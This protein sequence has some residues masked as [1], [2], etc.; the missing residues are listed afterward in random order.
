MRPAYPEDL[1]ITISGPAGSGKSHCA[2]KLAERFGIPC[3]S[4]GSVFRTMAAEKGVPVVEFSKIAESN[5]EIDRE[6]D[7]RTAE[8]AKKG[9]AILE[10]RLVMWFS[11]EQR[12]LSFYLTAPFEE[13]VRRIAEREG[14]PFKDAFSKTKAREASERQR[15]RKIYS[16][17]VSDLSR[18]DFVVN[19]AKWDK[20]AIVELL[21]SII[22]LH[23]KPKPS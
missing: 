19:T 3:H 7:R 5:H 4:A 22:E 8:L 17:D 2:N 10:G 14:I 13:R 20:D 18:Y 15:Y 16:V 11:G 23:I 12:K 1:L 21:A 9:G 6:V